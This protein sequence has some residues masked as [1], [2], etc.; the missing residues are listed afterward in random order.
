MR[1][2]ALT[3]GIIAGM[4]AVII[5]TT[6]LMAIVTKVMFKL[7]FFRTIREAEYGKGKN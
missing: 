4:I 5:V 7:G 6:L 3:L 1:Y 2:L